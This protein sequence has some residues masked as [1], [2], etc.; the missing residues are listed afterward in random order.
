MPVETRLVVRKDTSATWAS[1]NPV[2]FAGEWGYVTDLK[3]FKMGDGVTAWTA[4]PY[5]GGAQYVTPFGDGVTQVY[6]ITHNLGT[7]DCTVT[8]R[9]ATAPFDT[10]IPDVSCPT[11][12]TVVL[13]FAPEF[14]PGVNAYRVIIQA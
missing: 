10:V 4:L 9:R 13:G 5:A 8:V 1:V 12:N 14:I 3:L 6:T 2:L 11:P 7:R